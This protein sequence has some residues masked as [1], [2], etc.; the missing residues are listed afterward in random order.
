M[1]FR[2]LINEL[3]PLEGRRDLRRCPLSRTLYDTD[4]DIRG[5][6]RA[7]DRVRAVRHASRRTHP[8]GARLWVGQPDAGDD[9]VLLPDQRQSGDR[10]VQLDPWIVGL[11]HGDDRR[12]HHHGTPSQGEGASGDHD[13]SVH[14]RPRSDRRLHPASGAANVNAVF[15][16][17]YPGK[18]L[19]ANA[20]LE[21][22]HPSPRLPQ[23]IGADRIRTEQEFPEHEFVPA[24]KESAK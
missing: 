20:A 19:A 5:I 24:S 9:A 17:N 2:P 18:Y 8:P 15:L 7:S 23:D 16:V 10:A 14:F 6:G 13:K 3:F 22:D 4:S 12:R 1:T 11:H 21:N